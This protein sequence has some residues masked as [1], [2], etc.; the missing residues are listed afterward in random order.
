MQHERAA[1]MALTFCIGF[2]TAFI[3]YGL[4]TTP[5]P[6]VVVPTTQSATALNAQPV[7][8]PSVAPV[9]STDNV[10]AGVALDTEGLWMQAGN[11]RLLISPSVAAAP[12]MPEA[13][14][15]IHQAVVR[16]DGTYVFFC[17]ETVTSNGACEPR[18]FA[19]DDFRVYRVEA[20]G[21]TG[22]LEPAELEVTW[23]ANGALA[24]NGFTSVSSDTPW[25]VE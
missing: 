5:T 1:I 9:A 8:R 12:D 3:A 17:A 13:H 23:L 20:A 24:I 6:L 14:L 11:E 16:T 10:N 15:D 18:V 22:T 25:V 19:M 2:T 4:P 21:Q 7:Q